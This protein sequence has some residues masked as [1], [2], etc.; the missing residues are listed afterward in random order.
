MDNVFNKPLTYLKGVGPEKVELLKKELEL[1]TYK[2]VLLHFPFRYQD[3]SRVLKIEEIKLGLDQGQFLGKLIDIQLVKGANNSKRLVAWISDG[4]SELEM[5]W[6][7][8]IAIL[9]KYLEVGK[10]YLVYG[11]LTE[12]KGKISMSHPELN[13]INSEFELK[14]KLGLSPVYPLT[15]KLNRKGMDSSFFQKMVAQIIEECHPFIL[16]NLSVKLKES[17]GL[18]SR[19]DAF[20]LIHLP[21]NLQESQKAVFRIKFEEL[22]FNQLGLLKE[23]K[24]QIKKFDGFSCSKVGQIFNDFYYNH[25]PYQL[26]N[27]QKR[28]IKEI[29]GDLKSG[30]QLNRLIQGDVGSGKTI[31]A[32]L[33]ML[34]I[35]GNNGQACF[36]APTEILA[37]QH[38]LGLSRLLD[39]LDVNI[40]LLTGSTKTAD[41]K[42]IGSQLLDGSLHILVGTHAI[43]EDWVEF[44]NLGMAVI[45]EQHK[46]GVAQRA[47]LW[48]KNQVHPHIL[49]M[50]ATPIPRTLAMTIYGDL[51]V[52]VIDELPPGRKDV[53]T[54]LVYQGSRLRVIGFMKEQIKLGRQVYVVYPLIAESE[55]L[56]LAN[57][58]QGA[59]AFARDFPEPEY[60]ISIVHG[61]LGAELKEFEMQRF[62]VGKTQILISTTVIEVGVDVPNA[63]VMIIENAERFGLSQLH[64]LRGRVGRGGNQS[65]CF[66]MAGEKISKE[67]KDRLSVMVETNDGFKIAER[68]MQI[69]GPG[70]MAGTKQSGQIQ[71]KLADLTTDQDILSKARASAI[72]VVEE[73]PELNLKE[74]QNILKFLNQKKPDQS[75]WSMIS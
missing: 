16:E 46:F 50:T 37:T 2:D 49:V 53:E 13:I 65:F 29:Y 73:D 67:A 6:F 20:R 19:N 68:D 51:D 74:N 33:S 40:E 66:L 45:D 42:K 4:T 11:R 75:F 7:Q 1:F 31:V 71:F 9:Q 47:K 57:L 48:N 56:D 30:H 41:R 25:L 10:Q 70:E 43:L 27:A 60:L 15:E 26:T 14:S 54:H 24:I 55:K 39:G 62:K 58:I 18:I 61:K 52:S 32:L 63:T 35:L 5:V 8:Q 28:V 12:F 34:I 59:E 36:L 3:R 44:R 64:Q 17:L 72:Q 38:F 21:L 23:K 69:R 22:F